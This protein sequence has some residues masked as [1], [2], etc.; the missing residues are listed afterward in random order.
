MNAMK[1]H[2][3]ALD[4]CSI[5][6]NDNYAVW[7]N[8]YISINDVCFPDNEWFDAVSSILDMWTSVII[9]FVSKKKKQCV[10]HFMDGPFLLILSKTNRD[11][12]AIS[13]KDGDGKEIATT[14]IT[15]YELLQ[16]LLDSTM[17]FTGLCSKN[18]LCF[19]N[20]Q[21]YEKIFS[22]S[23]MLKNMLERLNT[24]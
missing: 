23:H 3:D 16:S 2:I 8:I 18:T 5:S 19:I 4:I 13:C 12:I 7:G 6:G 9:E 17:L 24:Q 11:Y 22:A 1:I 15:T 21:M 10:L 14:V 20:T